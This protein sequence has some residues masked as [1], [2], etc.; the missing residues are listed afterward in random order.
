[1]INNA[2][3]QTSKDKTLP[4]D[5]V[6]PLSHQI[7][8]YLDSIAVVHIIISTIMVDLSKA[9]MSYSSFQKVLDDLLQLFDEA[10]D[11]VV[12]VLAL[13]GLFRMEDDVK[14]DQF[15]CGS[16]LRW[17]KVRHFLGKWRC[18]TP[19]QSAYTT[20]FSKVL[21]GLTIFKH[22]DVPLFIDTY[23]NRK[24]LSSYDGKTEDI[25]IDINTEI[26]HVTHEEEKNSI[27]K[28]SQLI[29]SDNKNIIKGCW[30]GLAMDDN[31]ESVYGTFSFK[32]TLF[33]LR[34]PKLRQGEIVSYKN[35]VNVILYADGDNHLNG[36]QLKLSA[37][38]TG[39][40]KPTENCVKETNKNAYVKVSIFV[41]SR[42]LQFNDNYKFDEVFSKPV[43]VAHKPFCVKEKRS[44]SWLC[45]ELE[46]NV[47]ENKNY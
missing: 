3:Q 37:D 15:N 40:K 8:L 46:M 44:G 6:V 5:C 13:E 31:G 10:K 17:D 43:K 18:E 26:C 36:E 39:L 45:K 1:M 47:R 19:L 11:P 20:R 32:T 33:K 23:G 22:F 38:F 42:I 28:D 29:P 27:D 25:K 9:F 16:T 30:F 41:P 7:A 4:A 34:V 35:E 24:L 21:R 2:S 14:S 12:A